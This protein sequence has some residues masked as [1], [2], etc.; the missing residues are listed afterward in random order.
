MLVAVIRRGAEVGLCGSCMDARAIREDQIVQGA[1][2]SS[3]DELT[4]WTPWAARAR[5]DQRCLF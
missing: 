2:R 3:L 1:R 4:D 5:R